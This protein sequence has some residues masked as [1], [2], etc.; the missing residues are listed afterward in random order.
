MSPETTPEPDSFSG[1]KTCENACIVHPL[2]S[3]GPKLCKTAAKKLFHLF[4]LS[5]TEPGDVNSMYIESNKIPI[6]QH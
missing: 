1:A 3:V 5:L 4:E 6:G 2:K